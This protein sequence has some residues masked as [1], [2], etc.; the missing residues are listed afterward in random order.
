LGHELAKFPVEPTFAKSLLA[1][2]YVSKRCTED[3]TKLLA[4]LSAESIWMG[5]SKMDAERQKEFLKTKEQFKVD[6]CDHY[7]LVLIYNAW[8][9]KLN[10]SF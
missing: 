2:R 5:V 9:Q 7:P 4:V 8:R 1:S 3:F 10:E 6:L